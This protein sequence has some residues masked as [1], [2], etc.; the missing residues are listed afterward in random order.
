[1]VQGA[2]LAQSGLYLACLDTF[3]AKAWLRRGK[4]GGGRFKKHAFI[5]TSMEWRLDK[6]S[7]G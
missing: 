1:V 7:L 5:G 6:A 3:G 4:P 2:S